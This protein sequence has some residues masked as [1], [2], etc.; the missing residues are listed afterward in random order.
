MRDTCL[1]TGG[2]GFI[3]RWVVKHL[4]DS[5]KDVVVLDDASGGFTEN[6]PAGANLYLGSITNRELVANIF[7]HHSPRF[8]FH[9]A[10]YAAEGLSPFIRT[11]NC[12][13]NIEGSENII[14]A[15]I[16]H[17][18]EC[19]V[20]TSSIAVYGM[21]T[22]PFSER[23][24]LAPAD[25]YGAAKAYVESSLVNARHLH[26]LNS[27]VF[28]PYNV[29]GPFQNCGDPYRNVI[30][31]FMRCCMENR[32]MTI[33][34]DGE[35]TRAFS[36]IDD[37]APAIAASVDRP[38]SWNQVFNIGG[39][40]PFSVNE[41]SEVVANAMG[42]ERRVEMLPERHEAMHAYCSNGKSRA[43]FGDLMAN[44]SL[45][46]GIGRMAAWVKEVGLRKSRPF[47]DIEIMRKLPPSWKPHE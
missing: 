31:I 5:G 27:V 36:Y 14:T 47:S 38:D 26:R 3:G 2:L 34:G 35:Q 4:L 43:M 37:V 22:P 40:C 29:Y 44:V 19:L 12:R 7:R 16:N 32:P 24:S 33:F 23:D 8:V 28:R 21:G 42:V 1:V 46:D 6:L 30:G 17:G 11:F 9:L 39:A 13:N 41:L 10:A 18:V 20:F 15:C 45:A 25:P